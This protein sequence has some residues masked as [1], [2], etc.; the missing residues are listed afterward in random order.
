VHTKQ[1]LPLPLQYINYP[2]LDDQFISSPSW[3]PSSRFE[4]RTLAGYSSLIYPT[5]NAHVRY[6]IAIYGLSESAMFL[7]HYLINGTNFGKK[8]I[9][10]KMY[11]LISSTALV[12][13]I[14]HSKR[15]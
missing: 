14:S 9:V 5:C 6:C 13:N 15:N 10:H 1:T 2:T 3:L 12:W 11:I 7:S 8:V 4:L